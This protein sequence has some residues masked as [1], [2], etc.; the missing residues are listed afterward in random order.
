MVKV[1]YYITGH[2]STER[3]LPDIEDLSSKLAKM[4][5][6][7]LLRKEYGRKAMEYAKTM[8]WDFACDKW[9]EILVNVLDPTSRELTLLEAT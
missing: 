2:Y 1:A 9:K 3:P 5:D 8:T 4:Y 6:N 7:P